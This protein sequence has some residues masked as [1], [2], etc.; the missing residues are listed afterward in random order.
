MNGMV[1][2][3][4][5]FWCFVVGD[6]YG[7]YGYGGEEAADKSRDDKV[8]AYSDDEHHGPDEE[9]DEEVDVDMIG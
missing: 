5:D 1:F 7:S 3:L 6:E 2:L 9:I 8:G 4:L